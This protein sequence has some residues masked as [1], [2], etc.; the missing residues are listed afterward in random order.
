M[1]ATSKALDFIRFTVTY[2][3]LYG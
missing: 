3:I 1:Q 2:I